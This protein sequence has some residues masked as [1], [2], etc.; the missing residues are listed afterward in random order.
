MAEPRFARG[1]EA[2][3]QFGPA[4]AGKFSHR[5]P[6]VILP[7]QGHGFF[8]HIVSARYEHE[9]RKHLTRFHNAGVHELGDFKNIDD[10]LTTRVMIRLRVC[11]DTVGGPQIYSDDVCWC[12][13]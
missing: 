11:H 10:G 6:A 9:G 13:H 5:Q 8:G 3:G 12:C 2:I 4:L 1:D 7:G